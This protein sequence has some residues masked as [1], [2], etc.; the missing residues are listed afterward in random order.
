MERRWDPGRV[1]FVAIAQPGWERIAQSWGVEYEPLT[2]STVCRWALR[3]DTRMVF[4]GQPALP[5]LFCAALARG[6]GR[7]R[8]DFLYDIHDLHEKATKG[9][10]G[11]PRWVLLGCLEWACLRLGRVR[12]I[13]VSPGLVREVARRYGCHEP[14]LCYSIPL[15][16]AARKLPYGHSRHGLV[17]F[18]LIED[19]RLS[20]DRLNALMREG[21]SI[22]VYGRL[23]PA[24]R[25]SF[26]LL[27]RYETLKVVQMR[28]EYRPDD[29][30]FLDEYEALLMDFSATRSANV[31]HCLPN[32]LFLAL[33]HGLTVLVSPNLEDA[34][35]VFSSI[36]GAVMPL[37]PDTTI[38][39]VIRRAR[40]MR[41]VD[42]VERINRR[43]DQ[44]HAESRAAY[45]ATEAGE[46]A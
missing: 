32:K 41:P 2:F 42:Y 43:L 17:Y 45:L 35:A 23:V 46:P 18:G 40:S 21:L 33:R 38:R 14:S 7:G 19:Y 5:Y 13:T 10:R 6:L 28:G 26:E 44:L 39:E 34:I 15:P 25:S 31:R 11:I 36:P 3:P 27:T 24:Y 16:A 9:I 30:D 29:L 1:V 12:A 4:H 22:A 37:M 8:A 20:E